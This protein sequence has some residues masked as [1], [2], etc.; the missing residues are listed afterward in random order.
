MF[1]SNCSESKYLFYSKVIMNF[2]LRLLT[3]LEVFCTF[4]SC[5]FT[6]KIKYITDVFDFQE[7]VIEH[8]RRYSCGPVPSGV[9]KVREERGL[10]PPNFFTGNLAPPKFHGVLKY[11]GN[12][13]YL[14]Q[15]SLHF[16]LKITFSKSNLVKKFKVRGLRPP[17]PLSILITLIQ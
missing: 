3:K 1:K 13:F 7:H 8:V 2:S 16:L 12:F 9:T 15:I 17:N 14:F 10:C 4:W 5:I 6:L 11:N